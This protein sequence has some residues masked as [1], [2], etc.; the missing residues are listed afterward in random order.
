MGAWD[1]LR[2]T[3]KRDAPDVLR[4]MEEAGEEQPWLALP[5]GYDLDNLRD[6]LVHL[7]EVSWGENHETA[8]SQLMWTAATHGEHRLRA[9]FSEALLLTEYHLLRQ[10]AWEYL[11]ERFD[12]SMGTQAVLHLDHAITDATS[13]SLF[14]YHRAALERKGRWP[15]A[16]NGL[17]ERRRGGRA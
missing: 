16:V 12:D 17:I 13:A 14:G 2:E 15:Q 9:G 8:F 11:I 5:K 10:R 3:F 1:E 7:A 4:A 6:L